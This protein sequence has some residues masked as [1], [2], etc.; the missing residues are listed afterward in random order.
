MKQLNSQRNSAA[1]MLRYTFGLL[2]AAADIEAAVQ[3][4]LADGYRTADIA[5]EGEAVIGTKECGDLIVAAI[6]G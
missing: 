1:M 4:V 6:R 5:K 3:K 2:D